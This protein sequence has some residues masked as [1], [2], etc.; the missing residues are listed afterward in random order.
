MEISNSS[1][2]HRVTIGSY[3]KL[4]LIWTGW[5]ASLEHNGPSSAEARCNLMF[6]Q[7]GRMVFSPQPMCNW[8]HDCQG[9][10]T[11]QSSLH[12]HT[13]GATSSHGLDKQQLLLGN[14]AAFI[15]PK[16]TAPCDQ[17]RFLPA[18]HMRQSPRV[19]I[20]TTTFPK[21]KPSQLAACPGRL[22]LPRAWG[23]QGKHQLPVTPWV[24]DSTDGIWPELVPPSCSFW[25]L[26]HGTKVQTHSWRSCTV[27]WMRIA[28][29]ALQV[30][31]RAQARRRV[32][33]TLQHLLLENCPQKRILHCQK[34]HAYWKMRR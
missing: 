9:M 28:A 31:F 19:P 15:G 13:Q 11:A 16:L 23:E 26:H 34:C 6:L 27:K 2:Y 10:R 24:S 8:G 12:H 22:P 18:C 32:G 25:E 20:V 21:Q 3:E 30:L 5:F 1:F 29:A 33:K 17:C 14:K 7:A 4:R